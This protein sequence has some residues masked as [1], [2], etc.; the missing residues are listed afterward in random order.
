MNYNIQYEHGYGVHSTG[1]GYTVRVRVQYWYSTGK[2]TVGYSTGTGRR[3]GGGMYAG[4]DG[5]G[6]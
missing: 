5:G 3:V 2:T 6:G 4:S 1:T